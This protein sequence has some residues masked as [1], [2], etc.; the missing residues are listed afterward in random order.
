MFKFNNIQKQKSK[1]QRNAILYKLAKFKNWR[2]C[3]RV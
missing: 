3:G 1:S 2:N